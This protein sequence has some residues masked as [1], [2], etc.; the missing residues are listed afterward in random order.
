MMVDV[1]RGPLIAPTND[2]EARLGETNL[3]AGP[4]AVESG[5][6]ARSIWPAPA[7]LAVADPP[8]GA[9]FPRAIVVS[10]HASRFEGRLVCLLPESRLAQFNLDGTGSNTDFSYDDIEI[11]TAVEPAAAEWR[12]DLIRQLGAAEQAI[13][14][15]LPF[16]I[17]FSSGDTMRGMTRGALVQDGAL[18]LFE[19]VDA[20]HVRR[21]FVPLSSVRTYRLDEDLGHVL[22]QEQGVSREAVE[23]ARRE[24]RKA[25]PKALDTVMEEMRIVSRADL[26]RALHA[27]GDAPPKRFGEVL[28]DMHLVTPEQLT[29][30]LEYQRATHDKRLGQTLV[31]MGIVS[32]EMLGRA[33]PRQLGIPYIDLF[34]VRPDREA[35]RELDAK[36]AASYHAIPVSRYG[37]ALVVAV[38]HPLDPVPLD[39]L[40][41]VTGRQVIPVMAARSQ[42]DDAILRY[43]EGLPAD[44]LRGGS[45]KPL[46]LD[47]IPYGGTPGAQPIGE[48][49]GQLVVEGA[50]KVLPVDERP[51]SESDTTLVRLV[52]TMILDAHQ[53]GASDIHVE[54]HPG[55]E[56]SQIRFRRDGVLGEYIQ[57]PSG[58]RSA[59][60]TRLKI[61]ADLDISEHRR[62]QDGKIMFSRFGPAN[63]ELRVA[64]VP[65]AGGVEDIVLRILASGKPL[66]IEA[67]GIAPPLLDQ[68]KAMMLQ[69][70][71]I[72]LACGPTGSGKTTTLHSLLSFINTPERKIWTAEDPVE[73]TQPGLRQVQILPKIGWDFASILRSFLRADPD[74]IMVGEM[75]DAETAKIAIEASLTGHLVL[76]TLHT[77]GAIESV[78]RLLEMGMD[79]FN[80]ADALLGLVAQRLTRRL[81]PACRR[82]H[83]LNKVEAETLAQEFAL[84]S[85]LD[86][87]AVLARWRDQFG[88]GGALHIHQPAGCAACDGKGYKGRIGL[89]EI[90]R[91]SDHLKRLIRLNASSDDLRAQAIADGLVFLRQDGI[92]KVLQG[93]TSMDEVRAT[94]G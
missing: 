80:F 85:G 32:E 55:Q 11:I 58:F 8:S 61:M 89:Y 71:G 9:A 15:E 70:H 54:S 93:Q 50:A 25:A 94:T 72:I 19:P 22:V 51:V 39:A 59:L 27:F 12:L 30:A 56:N 7:F 34:T 45:A 84:Q 52:N 88:S 29:R 26:D 1:H 47:E 53:Q 14:K 91:A 46:Q 31:D 86:A 36:T 92:E 18:Y 49:A 42:I 81:C 5:V 33:R 63:I 23:S 2:G 40:R 3:K 76:S 90:L 4:H 20:H 16:E 43:Y 66:P 73:I 74:V 62:G 60:V 77:N 13:D 87:A 6:A 38:E 82:K 68:V 48:L 17:D 41:F 75:R 24:V 83:A 37:E 65:T 67:L 57:V 79:R 78:A 69:P 64:V 21:H 28:L 35:M 10:R 44:A